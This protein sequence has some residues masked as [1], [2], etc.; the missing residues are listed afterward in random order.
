MP[1][2][3]VELTG[4]QLDVLAAQLESSASVRSLIS[5]S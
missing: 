3:G 5:G 1:V 4:E 2:A